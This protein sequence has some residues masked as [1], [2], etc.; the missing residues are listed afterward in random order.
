MNAHSSSRSRAA[1]E[2]F[3]VVARWL[4]GAAFLYLGLNKALHPVEFLKLVRQY[5][6]VQSSLLLN[7]MAA[8][9]PWFEVLLRTAAAGGCGG[10]GHGLDAD[11][12][13]GAVHDPG[14]PARPGHSIG[15]GHPVLR[16]EIRL[17]LRDRRSLYLSQ[18]AGELFFNGALRLAAGR[19]WTEVLC[20]SQP[21]RRR[22]ETG[23]S[24][25]GAI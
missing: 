7:L 11:P 21:D 3:A 4:L 6:L 22:A 2:L 14:V 5:E 16:G 17:R 20:P 18:T 13:A 9:L 8:I 19:A 1:A 10:A 23:V 24:R 15:A 25:P 12:D